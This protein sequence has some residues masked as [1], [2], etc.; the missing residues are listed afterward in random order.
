[1]RCS[2]CGEEVGSVSVCPICGSE[3]FAKEI[4][5]SSAGAVR[6]AHDDGVD[7]FEKNVNGVFEISSS[8]ARGSGYLLSSDGLGIT[9]SHV[10]SLEDGKSCKNCTVKV[11]GEQV[12]A[13]VLAMGT[14]KN[15]EHA[16]NL[17]L[18][19]IKLD[20]VPYKATP[21]RLGDSDKVR[22]G[23]RIFVI[24]NSLGHGTCI[25][26]GIISDNDREGQFMYDCATNPGNSGG[27][28]FNAEGLV[29]GTHVRGT[30]TRGGAK[31]Q[32]MNCAIPCNE[33]KK[34]LRRNGVTIR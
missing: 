26:S 24:G 33:V 2:C 18:A 12:S 3:V 27:P 34:F 11:A 4:A 1:M 5:V 10:V 28:V 6:E 29:V 30:L 14:E 7:V 21:V 22:T 16:T 20:C 8:T 9:N 13:K 15:S 32:G 25:T 17:D 23:E 31:A 19:L